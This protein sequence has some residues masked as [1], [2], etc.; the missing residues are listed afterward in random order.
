MIFPN[1]LLCYSLCSA[2]SATTCSQAELL[3][4][5]KPHC[6]QIWEGQHAPQRELA[7]TWCICGKNALLSCPPFLALAPLSRHHHWL[8]DIG[9]DILLGHFAYPFSSGMALINTDKKL[10][11]LPLCKTLELTM[12]FESFKE[13][14]GDS[15]HPQCFIFLWRSSVLCL[16]ICF[17]FNWNTRSGSEQFCQHNRVW[18]DFFFSF[19][20][21]SKSCSHTD[22]RLER[23][24]KIKVFFPNL[25]FQNSLTLTQHLNTKII[26]YLWQTANPGGLLLVEM[27]S[28][29]AVS[30]SLKDWRL[31]LQKY[32]F[33]QDNLVRV[34]FCSGSSIA[35]QGS[36]PGRGKQ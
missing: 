16:Q 12:Y 21:F 15:S 28:Y 8:G 30:F 10:M 27:F 33:F 31:S 11:V 3:V 36:A 13:S 25:V 22:K 6:S 34:E 14:T 20:I 19:N 7:Q 26:L 9:L 32:I 4:P 5:N 17:Y 18:S 29:S 23:S 2:T 1:L 35:T 24:F